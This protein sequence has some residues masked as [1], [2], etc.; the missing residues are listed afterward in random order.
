[1]QLRLP[2]FNKLNTADFLKFREDERPAFERFRRSLRDEIRRQLTTAADDEPPDRIARNVEDDYLRPGLAE[3]EQQLRGSRRAL[4]K[5][6]SA[7]LAIGSSV[8]TIGAIA[9]IPMPISGTVTN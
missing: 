8:A 9:S 3:I 1:M 6:S 4:I 2:V 7:S 5:K